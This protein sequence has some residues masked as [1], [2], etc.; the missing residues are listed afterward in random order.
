MTIAT[1]CP[2][3]VS[4]RTDP[5]LSTAPP[6]DPTRFIYPAYRAAPTEA[7]TDELPLNGSHQDVAYAFLC[8]RGVPVHTLLRGKHY[9]EP[10]QSSHAS[11]RGPQGQGERLLQGEPHKPP[12]APGDNQQERLQSPEGE[13]GIRDVDLPPRVPGGPRTLQETPKSSPQAT[14]ADVRVRCRF[15][16]AWYTEERR[17]ALPL[18]PVR[19]IV[20]RTSKRAAQ[21]HIVFLVRGYREGLRGAP[22]RGNTCRN[23][24][25]METGDQ[26]R[27]TL[28]GQ[29][30]GV[31]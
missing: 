26:L 10:A 19:G 27:G 13:D 23:H 3:R 21:L 9:Q 15:L 16:E 20:H 24:Q 29:A 1:A 7:H 14:S 28:H 25:K 8:R 22:P 2:P 6:S 4:G 18:A 31:P 30:R 11:W 5:E 12:Q 17:V